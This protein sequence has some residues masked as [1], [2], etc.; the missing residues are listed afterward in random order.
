MHF[1]K[2]TRPHSFTEKKYIKKTTILSHKVHKK[3]I[4]LLPAQIQVSRCDKWKMHT[5]FIFNKVLF[6][7]KKS[8]Q[9]LKY[10]M[11][12]KGAWVS[13]MSNF[14][15]RLFY[16]LARVIR[17][18]WANRQSATKKSLYQTHLKQSL[19][20]HLWALSLISRGNERNRDRWKL[21]KPQILAMCQK[22]QVPEP[23]SSAS[24]CRACVSNYRK[25]FVS[26]E[27]K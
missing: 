23:F 5:T 19:P 14:R 8:R 2:P 17:I 3:N 15:K 20:S 26:M 12:G 21:W 27:K 7:K 16:I 25:M 11:T 10:G 22:Q 6:T 1:L 4:F 18:I 13:L 9:S 24:V